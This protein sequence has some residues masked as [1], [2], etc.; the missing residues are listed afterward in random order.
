V[1]KESDLFYTHFSVGNCEVM[2]VVKNIKLPQI[3]KD[4]D[5]NVVLT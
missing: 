2:M 4:M 3:N 1:V 5:N